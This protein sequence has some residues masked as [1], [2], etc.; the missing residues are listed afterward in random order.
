M[1]RK[2]FQIY[3]LDELHNSSKQQVLHDFFLFKF[4]F[5]SDDKSSLHSNSPNLR[6]RPFNIVISSNI[7]FDMFVFNGN[8]GIPINLVSS[9]NNSMKIY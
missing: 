8:S 1:G 9:N 7:I 2:C 6:E 4:N 5:D 3:N